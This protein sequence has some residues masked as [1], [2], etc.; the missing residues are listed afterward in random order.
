MSE[1]TRIDLYRD[2]VGDP[3]QIRILE[4]IDDGLS[5]Q[6]IINRIVEEMSDD[7]V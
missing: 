7:R 2:L 6:D 3:V 4:L 1:H 5:E